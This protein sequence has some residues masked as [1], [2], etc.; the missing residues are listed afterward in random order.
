MFG[1]YDNR[2]KKGSLLFTVVYF[3]CVFICVTCTRHRLH[4]EAR[5]LVGVGSL[6]LFCWC[7]WLI[8]VRL[9]SK[10]F[11]PL[12]QLAGLVCLVS[13]MVFCSPGWPWTYC[14]AQNSL[15]FLTL[16]PVP[17]KYWYYGCAHCSMCDS[18]E[19]YPWASEMSSWLRMLATF[20]G[21]RIWFLAPQ[22]Q[23]PPPVTT[24]PEEAS[25]TSSALFWFP[26]YQAY[27]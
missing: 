14:V 16:L 21:S 17:P 13:E 25:R 20:Q 3:V 4:A 15:E 27:T 7:Q 6:P 8:F 22:W 2:K 26:W 12:S 18:E 23:L 11:Y 24:V 9:R 10:C 1:W 5:Q 19:C